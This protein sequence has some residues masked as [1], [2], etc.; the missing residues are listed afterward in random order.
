VKINRLSIIGLGLIGSSIALA[1]RRK[2]KYCEIIGYDKSSDVRKVAISRRVIDRAATSASAA[3]RE[4]DLLLLAVPVDAAKTIIR[5]I[6]KTLPTGAVVTD[7]CSTKQ[8]IVNLATRAFGGRFVGSHPMFGSEK[9]GIENADAAL[10]RGAKVLITPTNGTDLH[11]LR[12]IES[13]WKSL[14]L[15]PMQLDSDDHD[16]RLALASHLP[17]VLA[18]VLM[19]QQTNE[20]IAVAGRGLMDTTRLAASDGKL[21]ESILLDNPAIS[22][23]LEKTAEILVQFARGV[24]TGKCDAIRVCFKSAQR[25]RSRLLKA[26]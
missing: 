4:C 3:A 12:A 11:A 6:A 26:E 23:E 21:W 17:Q 16:R 7:T 22:D 18:S 20:S 14:G 8:S 13:F 15:R 24:R 9:G 19:A 5:Q 1:V 10:L 25:Y 2:L